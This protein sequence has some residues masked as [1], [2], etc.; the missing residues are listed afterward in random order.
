MYGRILEENMKTILL[1]EDDESLNRG[2]TV[3]LQKEGYKVYSAYSIAEA[4]FILRTET[5]A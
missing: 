5:L 2:I 4:E 3:T 1:L